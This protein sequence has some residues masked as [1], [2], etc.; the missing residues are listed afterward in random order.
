MGLPEAPKDTRPTCAGYPGT[1]ACTGDDLVKYLERR[2]P[3]Y[4]PHTSPLYSNIAYSLLGM[5]VE[6]VTKQS[7]KDAIRT[8]IFDELGMKSSSFGGY[9]AGFP[10]KG[11]IPNRDI[12]WN[13]TLGV[14]ES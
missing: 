8:S 4:L 3:V 9:P 12:T 14:F 13:A 6:A 5:I 1:K 10:E 7:F 2:P 11:Y